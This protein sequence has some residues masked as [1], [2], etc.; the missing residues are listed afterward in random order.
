LEI[1][2]G[3]GRGDSGSVPVTVIIPAHDREDT[4]AR[5]VRSAIGQEPRPPA[6][7]IVI[8]DS[9][10]DA[11]AEIARA[12]GARVI[13]HET[14]LGAGA[15]RN[16]G[17]AN[18]S[19]PWVALLDSDDEWLP[20]HL[21]VLWPRHDAHVLLAGAALQCV[22]RGPHRY[23]GT[24]SP[25]GRVIRSPAEIAGLSFLSASGVMVRRDVV[26]AAG[27][28]RRLYGVEDLDLW[29]RVLE[30]GSG[31]ASPV[32]SVL[33][34]LHDAQVSGDSSR[35]KA[36]HRAVLE[37][38]RE[39]P[40]FDSRVLHRWEAVVG[41][42]AA[43]AARRVGDRRTA[44]QHVARIAAH[45]GRTIELLRVLATGE[46]RRRRTSRFARSGAPTL[47]LLCNLPRTQAVAAAADGFEVVAPAGSNRFAQWMT[48][49]YRPTSAVVVEGVL[50]RLVAGALRIQAVPPGGWRR[51]TRPAGR[52]APTGGR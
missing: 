40:W 21:A 31:F 46:R 44:A 19:Q 15:A 20:H 17:I 48:L 3:S 4:I 25:R 5:A 42:D 8:D 29:L 18:A 12:A 7:V 26:L 43:R 27:G 22:P 14:N 50:D 49:G 2:T 41:W 16:T 11:T 52:R 24:V 6:E 1:V 51:R 33:Y 13:R 47:A 36:G 30:R 39:R 10:T 45:P 9:S 28:F 23:V 37:S 34:Y 38:S 32:V 35:M